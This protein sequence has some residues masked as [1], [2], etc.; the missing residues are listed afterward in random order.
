MMDLLAV[1]RPCVTPP[2][3]CLQLAEDDLDARTIRPQDTARVI[4]QS[5]IFM[6]E[7]AS[8]MAPA[9]GST[10]YVEAPATGLFQRRKLRNP[11]GTGTGAGQTALAK[12]CYV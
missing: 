1:N 3:V 10:L 5:S 12:V 8:R 9:D 2:L 7:N 6:Q 11:A 4:T